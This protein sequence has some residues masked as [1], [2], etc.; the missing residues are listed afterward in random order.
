M[1]TGNL[2]VL[3]RSTCIL[4]AKGEGKDRYVLEGTFS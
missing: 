2:L 1:E 4:E 3:E